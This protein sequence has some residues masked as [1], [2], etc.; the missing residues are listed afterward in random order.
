MAMA[1]N[2]YLTF[3]HKYNAQQLRSLEWKYIMLCYGCPLIPAFVY[4]FIDSPDKGKIY[5]SATV[6]FLT[7]LAACSSPLSSFGAGY[8]WSGTF[9]VS[10][11]SMDP[12]GLSSPAQFRYMS[13]PA[14]KSS[15]NDGSCAPSTFPHHSRSSR[16]RSYL[17][18]RP[19]SKSLASWRTC[20][21]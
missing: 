12:F 8:L 5:G 1:C 18:R 9:S 3:F 2:V 16:I 17:A 20:P 13:M 4:L 11:S 10:Q 19:R 15:P 21:P 14:R 6:S 7:Y